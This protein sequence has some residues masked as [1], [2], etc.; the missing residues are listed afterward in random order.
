FHDIR[1]RFAAPPDVIANVES[2]RHRPQHGLVTKFPRDQSFSLLA[3][4]AWYRDGRNGRLL[5]QRDRIGNRRGHGVP[6]PSY[7]I[8][9]GFTNTTLDCGKRRPAPRPFRP[10]EAA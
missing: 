5:A 3:V 1:K 6:P 2:D 4:R 7:Y 9:A 10:P 8:G